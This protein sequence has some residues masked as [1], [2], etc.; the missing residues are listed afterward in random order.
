MIP[1]QQR[2]I[3][4]YDEYTQA[5]KRIPMR[6]IPLMLIINNI[7]V[8]IIFITFA[9]YDSQANDILLKQNINNTD[10]YAKYGYNSGQSSF[11]SVAFL[12]CIY[13]CVA[14]YLIAFVRMAFEDWE[15]FSLIKIGFI[16]FIFNL[17]G[18]LF[19]VSLTYPYI[20]D[21]IIGPGYQI[22]QCD[23]IDS[24]GSWQDQWCTFHKHR[25]ILSWLLIFVWLT[26]YPIYFSIAPS[27]A[28]VVLSY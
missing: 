26:I 16:G 19:S 18:A 20:Q 22:I 2:K 6:I 24:L 21:Q 5:L 9:I 12:V 28:I 14:I 3:S 15:W 1:R 17:F 8:T 4:F 25:I 11:G 10:L 23:Y 27:I 13:I 7:F